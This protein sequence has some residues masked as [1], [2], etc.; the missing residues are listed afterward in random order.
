MISNSS[1]L[2][3]LAKLNKIGLLKRL[4]NKIIIPEE[5]KK[6]VLIEGREGY[7]VLSKAIDD[8]WI[9]IKNPKKNVDLG[10]GKGENAAIN[11]AREKKDKL[12]IDDAFAIKAVKSLN[13]EY[14]RTTTIILLSLKRRII[15]KKTTK[16]LIYKL[17]GK[18]YYISPAIFSKSIEIIDNFKPS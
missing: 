2:I 5:V 1:P 14:L 7:A 18:G 8:G 11:L 16:N 17:V 15:D 4:F 3:F 10:L 12:I 6:E 9:L 13:I